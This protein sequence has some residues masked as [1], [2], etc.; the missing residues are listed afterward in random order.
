[1]RDI[2]ASLC[3]KAKV[4]PKL[5]A[6]VDGRKAADVLLCGFDSGSYRDVAVDVTDRNPF[7]IGG[8]I[9]VAES[10]EIAKSDL[11]S[12]HCNAAGVAFAAF[13]FV[14]DTWYG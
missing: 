4:S 7:R 14:L 6:L 9:F 2:L 1:M 13:V 8:D 5:E 12:A 10:A 3:R 11:H